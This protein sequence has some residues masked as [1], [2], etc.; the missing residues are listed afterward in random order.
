MDPAG[1]K[2]VEKYSPIY[3][4]IIHHSRIVQAA[5]EVGFERHVLHL[6][7]R[8]RENRRYEVF[9]GDPSTLVRLDGRRPRMSDVT[10]ATGI[11]IAKN[12]GVGGTNPHAAAVA[13]FDGDG[14]FDLLITT[15]RAPHVR[16]FR[17]EG[18]LRFA[19][20]TKGSG[21]ESFK[22][23]GT[24]AAVADFDRDGKADVYLSSLRGGASRLY[25]GKGDGTFVDVSKAARALHEGAGRS[26]AWS[27]VDADGWVDL[28]VTCPGGANRLFRNNRN[29]T[30]TDIAA[31]A[32]TALP[33]RHS[34]GCAFGDVD[35]DGLD[36]L[37]VANYRSQEDALLKN[38][39]KG[40][41]RDVT[42]ASGLVRKAS[43]VGCVF[44]D[45]N[46]KGRLDLYVTTD[47]WLSGE[48][49]TEPQLLKRGHTVE[50]NL[51]YENDGRGRFKPAAAPVLRHKTLSH[52][53]ILEDLDHDG[54]IDIYVGVDAIPSGNRFATHKGGNPLW[55]RDTKGNWREERIVWGVGYEGNCV[56]VPAAD[57]DG[58]GDL[59]L[60]LVNFYSNVVVYRNDTNS[61][62]WL[63]VK[64]V[65]TKSNPD[66]IGAKIR[67]YAQNGDRRTLI[68][69][70]EIQSGTGYC[71]C[72]PLEVHFGLG[73]SPAKQYRVEVYFSASKKR[74]VKENVAPG[75]RIVIREE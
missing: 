50:P 71:R 65:G 47:S 5:N 68:G 46:G 13:D 15:F 45:V 18:K 64:A 73:K 21:L 39:G 52:D 59:D 58:D 4:G 67:V 54:R 7:G 51:L 12:T 10:A 37:F 19:D 2:L 16:Y 41:F 69:L 20:I 17:N 38:L 72:S 44:G 32:G 36:D 9:Y 62:S 3:G 40:R 74:I 6:V 42:A 29:G 14:D 24:G 8:H 55:T 25:K 48:N 28:Y 27:D 26:C 75:Q 70:R 34:L 57:L 11:T 66:G 61:R 31:A 43:S 56:C 63:R 30:F 1:K 49:Y 23:A 33:K 35:G 60:V 22:G 53:A